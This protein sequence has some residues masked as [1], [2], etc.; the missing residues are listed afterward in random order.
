MEA[1]SEGVTVIHFCEKWFQTFL[2]QFSTNH[3]K[4]LIW[5][6]NC[7]KE[8]TLSRI[9]RKFQ[10]FFPIFQNFPQN[11][12]QFS[13]IFHKI[14]RKS[15]YSSECDCRLIHVWVEVFLDIWK[16]LEK[17]LKPFST[18]MNHCDTFRPRL[19]V[20]YHLVISW[21]GA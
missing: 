2:R 11:F 15:I 12:P 16:L 1:R 3:A 17:S 21:N 18:K 9:F 4:F 5:C 14:F 8:E 10:K 7:I 6:R 13:R 19:K 20:L